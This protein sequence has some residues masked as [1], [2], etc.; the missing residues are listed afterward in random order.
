MPVEAVQ[1]VAA[2]Q[3]S[4]QKIKNEKDR[5]KVREEN[6]TSTEKN[7][8]SPSQTDFDSDQKIARDNER[9]KKAVAEMN[10]RAR[11]NTEVRYEIHDKMKSIMIKIV[12]KDTKKV[13]REYPPEETLDIAA[14]VLELAGIL[15][16][17][18]M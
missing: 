5:D 14:K 18:K 2:Y 12:D 11:G 3:G 4:T 9:V 6:A 15:V 16:D 17:E 1:Q 10:K 13:V 8:G 7:V